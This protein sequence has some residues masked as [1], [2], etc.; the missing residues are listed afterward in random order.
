M[1][2]ISKSRTDCART[3][4]SIKTRESSMRTPT[5]WHRKMSA[6][7]LPSDLAPRK[8]G[9]QRRKQPATVDQQ[10]V[11][12]AAVRYA[13][14]ARI[15]PL[16]RERKVGSAGRECAIVPPGRPPEMLRRAAQEL[17]I[18]AL[19]DAGGKMRM[20]EAR[21]LAGPEL[22]LAQNVVKRNCLSTT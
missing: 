7:T 4:R 10:A 12:L 2:R 11:S 13:P 14:T 21:V 5:V 1:V 17:R 16:V 9:R 6:S 22:V 8:S 3:N 20:A 19:D 15:S 18:E